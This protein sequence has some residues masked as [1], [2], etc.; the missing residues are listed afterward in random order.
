MGVIVLD[1]RLQT[2]IDAMSEADRVSVL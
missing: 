1:D 2:S